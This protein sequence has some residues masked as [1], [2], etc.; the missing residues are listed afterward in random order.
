MV[1]QHTA[2]REV[3]TPPL[4][5]GDHLTRTEFERRYAARPD[6]W[7]AELVEGIVY[8]PS[9]TR[10][11]RHG[12]PHARIM[13]WLGVYAVRIPIVELSDN[14]TVRMDLDNEPQPDAIL[15][16]PHEVGG[17]SRIDD[18]DYFTGAPEL[19]AEVASSSASYD[20]GAKKNA[21]RRNGVQEY[22]V[23]RVLDE[24]IDWFCLRDGA[25]ESIAP[26]DDGVLRSEAFPG[27]WLDRAALVVDRM[28]R[29]MEVLEKGLAS[30]DHMAFKS[31]LEAA[32]RSQAGSDRR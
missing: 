12:K 1:R 5:P 17:R 4:E 3:R 15:S 20:L 22:V 27:L 32:I 26:S 2:S 14:A 25:Y 30:P 29:V 23:W 11:R 9:P 28:D 16:L 18:D 7:K 31:R 8:V 13:T 6:V 19:I 21:Y 24:T 10:H